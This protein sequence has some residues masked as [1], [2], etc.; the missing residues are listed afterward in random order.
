MQDISKLS[1]IA[2][3]NQ[4]QPIN[5]Y[6]E[7]CQHLFLNYLYQHKNA[8]K[9]LFKG[10]TA[11]RIVYASPRYSEDLDFTILKLSK[12]QVEDTVLFVLNK[13]RKVNLDIELVESVE[14]SGGYI[15]LFKVKIENITV[16]IEINGSRRVDNAKRDLVLVDNLFIPAY[17]INILHEA[18]LIAEKFT[19]TLTRSK[20]RDFFDIY[21]LLRKGLIKEELRSKLTLLADI[22]KKKEVNF[23]KELSVFLPRSMQNIARNFDK[24]FLQEIS[25][26][27]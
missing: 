6:R 2:T 8:D 26:Y 25:K 16:N 18:D 22:L 10:G 7:Y 20:P 9:F 4:T 3:Q 12:K 27:L 17:T 14:T 24:V 11:L 19:A 21:F 23:E 15:A 13:M 1:E 5:V